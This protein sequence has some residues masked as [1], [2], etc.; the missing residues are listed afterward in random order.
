MIHH[1]SVSTRSEDE[2]QKL[3]FIWKKYL[4]ENDEKFIKKVDLPGI[5]PGTNPCEGFGIP[6]TYKPL[7]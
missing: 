5:E 7:W 4:N 1:S 6:F 3:V 2:N